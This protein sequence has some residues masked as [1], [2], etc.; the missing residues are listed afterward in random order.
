MRN[1]RAKEVSDIAMKT[2]TS[3]GHSGEK[4]TNALCIVHL[5]ALRAAKSVGHLLVEREMPNARELSNKF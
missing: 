3:P 1:E 5:A 2:Q 4:C